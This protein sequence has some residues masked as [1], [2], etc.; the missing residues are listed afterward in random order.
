MA[1]RINAKLKRAYHYFGID[2]VVPFEEIEERINHLKGIPADE[3]V[4]RTI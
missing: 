2:E 4:A 3:A 1:K